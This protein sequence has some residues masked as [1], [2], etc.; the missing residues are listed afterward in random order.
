MAK[1]LDIAG[2]NLKSLFRNKKGILF[3]ILFPILF[4]S[5]NG[6]IL[7]GIDTTTIE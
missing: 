3:T 5:V 2:K 4:Y 7:G 6:F 1:F